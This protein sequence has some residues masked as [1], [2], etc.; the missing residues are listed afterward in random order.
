VATAPMALARPACGRT[1]GGA[2]PEARQLP[3]T[4]SILQKVGSGGL[5][6]AIGEDQTDLPTA[7]G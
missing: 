2:A 3:Q 5:V 4:D 1:A 7:Y 6:V